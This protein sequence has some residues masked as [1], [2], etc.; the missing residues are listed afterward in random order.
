MPVDHPCQHLEALL[1]VALPSVPYPWWVE[2][3]SD[4]KS[5]VRCR[6]RHR[7][8]EACLS[9]CLLSLLSQSAQPGSDY[10]T[11]SKLH[12]IHN[13]APSTSADTL[14][15]A[16]ASFHLGNQHLLEAQALGCWASLLVQSQARVLWHWL[17]VLQMVLRSPAISSALLLSVLPVL[18]PLLQNLQPEL[19]DQ[20]QKAVC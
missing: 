15:T 12:N 16:Q 6:E 20:L 1:E 14:R 13:T 9:L 2:A 7:L 10:N 17:V 8:V 3:A 4:Q 11:S 5:Q 19:S 18:L